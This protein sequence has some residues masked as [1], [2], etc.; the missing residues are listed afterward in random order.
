MIPQGGYRMDEQEKKAGTTVAAESSRVERV[1]WIDVSRENR[2]TRT[3]AIV[4]LVVSIL[5]HVGILFS[6]PKHTF[7]VLP[8]RQLT[9]AE[10][11]R[12]REQLREVKVHLVPYVAPQQAPKPPEQFVQSTDAP[13]NKPDE[14]PFFSNKNQQASQIVE[15]NVKGGRIPEVAKGESEDA[16]ALESGMGKTQQ[17]TITD[18]VQEISPK[19]GRDKAAEAKLKQEAQPAKGTARTLPQNEEPAPALPKA[20]EGKTPKDSGKGFAEI[21]R[22]GNADKM[23]DKAPSVREIP[24]VMTGNPLVQMEIPRVDPSDASG[25]RPR[26][27]PRLML[28]GTMPSV[29]RKTR[30]GLATPNGNIAFDTKLSEFGDYLSRVLEAIAMKWYSLNNGATQNLNDSNTYVRVEFD[31]TKDGQ[32]TNLKIIETNSS[33]SAQW[34]CLDAIQS[35]APYYEWTKDM[36]V[37]LGDSQPVRIQFIYR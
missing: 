4:I 1:D 23:P 22:A 9:E 24:A 18:I 37:I 28:P 10:R 7:S 19:D 34:R 30:S 29:V 20:F 15:S 12:Q 5:F 3:T 32:V 35:N 21:E 27:R 17:P 6:L 33:Q 14:T 25:V 36:V 16:T 2:T 13:E 11:Q 31:V 8:P 26:P